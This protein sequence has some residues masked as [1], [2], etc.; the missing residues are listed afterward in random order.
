MKVLI[1]IMVVSAVL[2]CSTAVFA[3]ESHVPS[4]YPTIQAAIDAA[5][6]GDVVIVAPGTYTGEGNINISFGSRAITVRSIDPNDPKIVSSTI[7][8]CNYI[9]DSR[10]FSF[11]NGEDANSVLA[12]LTIT[13]GRAFS[14]AAISC[15]SADPTIANCTIIGNGA[16]HDGAIYLYD[17][18][19]TIANCLITGNR[20]SGI[21][22]YG[23]RSSP[24][25]ANCT[26]SNN[27]G[28][29]NRYGGGIYC[30]ERSSPII[31]NC[32]IAGNKV[33]WRGVVGYGGGIYSYF[34]NPTLIN[35]TIADNYAATDGGG[36]NCYRSNSAISLINCIF[37]GNTDQ[38]GQTES[39][40]IFFY[41]FG[42]LPTISYN[43][44]QDSNS[45]DA[46]IPFDANNFNIDDDP[47]FVSA[48]RWVDVNDINIPVE[49]NDPNA[50]WLKG[51]YHLLRASPC[52]EAGN[53]YTTFDP[54]ATD[55]FGEP[56]VF[57]KR[58]DIGADEFE[59]TVI[60]VTNPKGGEIWTQNSYHEIEWA[61]YPGSKA[62]DILFSEDG[63]ERW[64]V[65]ADDVNDS[66][67]YVWKL[68]RV[69]S[70][71]CMIKV[72]PGVED[73]NVICT[74]SGAFSIWPY[75]GPRG[76][77]RGRKKPVEKY[78]PEY[79]CVKWKFETQGP[80][81]AAVTLG[82]Q[83]G[84]RLN[85]YI[86]S[87]DGK[88]Y[89][90]DFDTGEV[91][92]SYDVNS[93]IAAS[94]AVDHFGTVYVGAEDGKLYAIDKDGQL[95]WTHQTGGP[96]YSSPVASRDGVYVCSLDGAMYA[97]GR[98]GSELWCF[99]TDGFGQLGGSIFATPIVSPPQKLWRPSGHG[100][101]GFAVQAS[102]T[103]HVAGLYDPNLYALNAADGSVKWKVNFAYPVDPCD[104][105]GAKKAGWPFATP[106]V[107]KDGTIYLSLI[108]NSEPVYPGTD[109]PLLY[110]TSLYAIE[111]ETGNVIW[112]SN[113]TD[114]CSGLYEPNVVSDSAWSSP[115]VGPDGM[116]YVSLDDPY[117][118]AVE[119][120]GAVK[121]VTEL[122]TVGAFTLSVGDDGLIYAA[123][124][125]KKLYVVSADG[126]LIAEFEG[127]GWLSF[128][129]LAPEH[130]IIVS[131]ANNTV[132]A[133]TQEDCQEGEIVLGVGG[134][135]EDRGL[136]SISM[137]NGK[138]R[139][140]E[141]RNVGKK[142]N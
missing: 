44:I 139:I 141:N 87:E 86:A 20:G 45:S 34:G 108:Y 89:A 15:E 40:Q 24:V 129:V 111:P 85:V 100:R 118:R 10:G 92:W 103:V 72:V 33:A 125:D 36:I 43:C 8:D 97:L 126:E 26:I 102:E 83:K 57:G 75:E 68:A 66:G 30:E 67:V 114:P 22:C 42:S 7:I 55:V 19:S 28:Y 113:M 61:S 105:N 135:S 76:G 71:Q 81:S 18:N 21:Y 1:K 27:T 106:A 78:G 84:K 49:P 3:A 47:C 82:E 12:G 13:H 65:I 64:K 39:A 91:V 134:E 80:L 120:N 137:K 32:L 124:D 14:G 46:N 132:W 58:V 98:D 48:G 51:D 9:S 142:G 138:P 136:P 6:A 110:Q 25:I 140:K 133:I 60:E 11:S 50:L 4:E 53:P 79:G 112:A 41:E 52:I 107:G 74:A 69:D 116:I 23:S 88:V 123:S 16:P 37:W 121:W 101:T 77:P 2:V 29:Q 31:T 96:I 131:D 104:P 90:V 130:T 56:R 95:L 109:W 62:V 127:G 73:S 35:C 115:V 63:G 59:I 94:A 54:D 93:P 117:L 17:S 70:D 5:A 38:T 122:G 119:P 99:E 128:P